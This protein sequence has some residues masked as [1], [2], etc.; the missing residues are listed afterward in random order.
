MSTSFNYEKAL[1]L[2]WNGKSFVLTVRNET[3]SSVDYL[4]SYDGA[5]WST[6]KDLSNSTILTS[7]NQYNVKWTGTNYAIIGNIATANGNTILRSNDGIQFS[8]MLTNI[9]AP[10]Y[11]LETNLEF[12]NTVTFPRNTTLAL[13]GSSSD[14]TKIAYSI[15]EGLTWI[16]S[17]NSAS[18]F[19]T[20]A[21]NA[22]WT[23]KTWIAVGQ[24]GNTIATSIDG[25]RW[26]GQGSYI[27]T[28]AGY[29]VAWSNEQ[30]LAVT[31]GSGTNS[32]AYSN[33]GVFWTGIGNALLSTVYDVQWNGSIWVA[34]G[35]PISGNKSIAYSTN[36]KQWNL[37]IQ[38]NLF[39]VNG[40]KVGWNGSFW[41]VIGSSTVGNGSYN[42][43]TSMD[44]IRWIM[45][46]N[47]SFTSSIQNI[48]S[49]P[50]SP[51]TLY[52]SNYSIEPI[53][54]FP[55]ATFAASTTSVTTPTGYSAFSSVVSGQT[56]GNGTYYCSAST[57]R[58]SPPDCTKPFAG[59][60]GYAS[61]NSMW[62]VNPYTYSSNTASGSTLNGEW[63]EIQMSTAFSPVYYNVS[64]A[65]G[66]EA[67]KWALIASNN[68]TTWT[69]LDI[70]A[71]SSIVS[72]NTITCYVNPLQGS[73][74][75]YRWYYITCR[76]DYLL[77]TRP[78]GDT[79]IYPTLFG[80]QFYG[81]LNTFI[82]SIPS[83]PTNLAISNRTATTIDILF[84]LPEQ[85]VSVYT[86]TA[87]PKPSGTPI[88]QTFDTKTT[89]YRNGS[90][91]GIF[92]VTGLTNGQRYSL[93]ITAA[94][95]YGVSSPITLYYLSDIGDIN[96]TY[97]IT[98][99]ATYNNIIIFTGNGTISFDATLTVETLIVGGGGGGGY[100][101]SGTIGGLAG[102]GGGGLGVGSLFFAGNT[103]YNIS[104]GNGGLS[105]LNG[106]NST[107][108]GG[109]LSETAYGGGSAGVSAANIKKNPG[110]GGSG[111]GGKPEALSVGYGG[112]ATLG[113]G[114]LTYYGN[115]GG[116]GAQFEGGGGG[117]AGGA[118]GNGLTYVTGA[119]GANGGDGYTWSINSSIYG[120][121]GGAGGAAQNSYSVFNSAG[122]TSQNGGNGASSVSGLGS[123]PS[124]GN[125]N[126]GGGG[127]GACNRSTNGAN[128]GSGVVI[129][130]YN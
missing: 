63:I 60:A 6:S 2:D 64:N 70:T 105:N 59:Y 111:G 91:T 62:Q 13:G 129:F 74:I 65:F 3:N 97:T 21:N 125:P 92:T 25:N 130:A 78:V 79:A 75:Y 44:G 38:T 90:F 117:G 37:P 24:G 81:T 16:P 49:S 95:S 86:I 22:L 93:T 61:T 119:P 19:T 23:G 89:A 115:S 94:N 10:L 83:P 107:I 96:G 55:P 66:N 9:S 68:R 85:Y 50:L 101:A 14:T 108:T 8:P 69:L 30:S 4:Y 72:N 12:N 82:G 17:A 98:S 18:V 113:S 123:S 52:Y 122:G 76:L 5:D 53:L 104:I 121:G 67:T 15:D 27:F 7:K 26:V 112:S 41:T 126:T 88:V 20:T 71:T 120:G 1:S 54:L 102:G 51:I 39:D 46:N 56:Y 99:N 34:C 118:G 36:G 127:G 45:Q 28:T 73:F 100:D 11:D 48:Y 87:T 77:Q 106:E 116:N 35:V 58:G 29:G 57:S 31:G 40:R 32:L 124:N 43:A 109:T 114:T 33:D 42:I 47:Q 80:L 110:N 103:T 128:G 84:T